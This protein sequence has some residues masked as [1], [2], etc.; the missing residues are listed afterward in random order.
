MMFYSNNVV[1]NKDGDYGTGQTCL[2]DGKTI[3]R[4]NKI[5]TPTG[6]VIEC[7]KDLAKWQ[8]VWNAKC[9]ERQMRQK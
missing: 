3:V 1:L 7:G 8:G 9:M 4:D 5:Y 2:G 6:K